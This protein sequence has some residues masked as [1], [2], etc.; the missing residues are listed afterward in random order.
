[1]LDEVDRNLNA[2]LAFPG[3]AQMMRAYADNDLALVG[4][5][6]SAFRGSRTVAFATPA[7]TEPVARIRNMFIDGLPMK[8]ATNML[9][10][11]R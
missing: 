6:R 8:R 5:S 3:N 11:S 1:M 2:G 10:G 9:A 7:S 4:S